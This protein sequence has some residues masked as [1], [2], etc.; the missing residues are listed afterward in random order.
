VCRRLR[1]GAP[2]CRQW[3]RV[4]PGVASAATV[5]RVPSAATRIR[6]GRAP[7][8]AYTRSGRVA[9]TA[10]RMA[11][12]MIASPIP[13]NR[14]Q[15][16]MAVARAGSGIATVPPT[17]YRA[18]NTSAAV[19]VEIAAP[20]AA[21][22]TTERGRRGRARSRMRVRPYPTRTVTMPMTSTFVPRAV[23]PPSA[24]RRA[25]TRK[26]T[27]ITRIAVH[28]PTRQAARTPPR[29]CPDV[30]APTGKLII[31]AAKTNA[32]VSPAS[33]GPDW[34]SSASLRRRDNPTAPTAI[35]PVAREVGASRKPSGTCIR[36]SWSYCEFFATTG[37]G[38]RLSA[39]PGTAPAPFDPLAEPPVRLA[40]QLPAGYGVATPGFR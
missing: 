11:A 40:G 13:I 14:C 4:P 18:V 19:G 32:A 17:T 31:C 24:K 22:G 38:P 3:R 7:R 33:A 15:P 34:R 36:A 8:A 27:V 37:P 20:T 10:P 12:V 35:A 9:T 2:P 16:I 39:F 26:T 6:S 5:R 23:S 21:A 1:R 29:R 30:P 25:W 28:G